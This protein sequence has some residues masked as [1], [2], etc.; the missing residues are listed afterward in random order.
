MAEVLPGNTDTHLQL[1]LVD[2]G[3]HTGQM[4]V[5]SIKDTWDIEV[6]YGRRQVSALSFTTYKDSPGVEQFMTGNWPVAVRIWDHRTEE[7]IEPDDSRFVLSTWDEDT[8]D[9]TNQISFTCRQD[10][11]TMLGR[12]VLHRVDGDYRLNKALDSAQQAYDDAESEFDSAWRSFA[13]LNMEIRHYYNW[14]GA[15]AFAYRGAAWINKRRN[16]PHGSIAS[17]YT[18]DGALFFFHGP[19]DTWK[20]LNMD[21][22]TE[23]KEELERLGMAAV[24]KRGG[25]IHRREELRK[26]RRAARETSV[27]GKRLFYNSSPGRTLAKAWVEGAA[28]DNDRGA[29]FVSNARTVKRVWR[30]WTNTHDSKGN[31]WPERISNEFSLGTSIWQMVEDFTERGL[32]DWKFQGRGFH[33]VPRGGFEVDQSHRVSLRLGQDVTE[34]T[35]SGSVL[36]HRSVMCVVG[37]TGYSYMVEADVSAETETAWGWWEGSVREPSAATS[38]GARVLT[39]PLRQELKKR[40]TLEPQMA[41]VVGAASAIPMI[42]YAPHHQVQVFDQDGANQA[43]MVEEI[44]LTQ[45]GANDPLTAAITLETRR[46]NRDVRFNKTLS[47]TVGGVSHIQGHVP[48]SDTLRPPEPATEFSWAPPLSEVQTRLRFDPITGVP[49]VVLTASFEDAGMP[50]PDDP[51]MFDDELDLTPT[52]PTA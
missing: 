3:K 50:E 36:D 43:R 7:W 29:S 11:P 37:G 47:K 26:A 14:Y 51:N 31:P 48:M 16:V 46:Q 1:A 24:Q 23:D 21:T 13:D 25:M 38:G 6:R 10:G 5:A 12:V 35:T 17:D 41:V 44:I 19:S 39:Q 27:D 4:P 32:I 15:K 49:S 22:Y 40:F 34:A 8:A 45:R 28:R 52:E 18:R 42:D 33:M 2:P 9:E 30:S 20:K